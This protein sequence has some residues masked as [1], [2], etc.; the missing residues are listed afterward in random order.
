[1]T[2]IIANAQ[3][4]EELQ[5]ARRSS[6]MFRTLSDESQAAPDPDKGQSSE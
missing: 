4:I 2:Q 1:M 6:D 5:D 3:N